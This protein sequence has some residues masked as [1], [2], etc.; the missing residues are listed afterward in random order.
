MSSKAFQPVLFQAYIDPLNQ[1]L[2][3]SKWFP[4]ALKEN[5]DARNYLRIAFRRS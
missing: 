1:S 5:P 2:L 4:S 3:A